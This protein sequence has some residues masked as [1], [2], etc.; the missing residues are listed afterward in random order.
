MVGKHLAPKLGIWKKAIK[1]KI[2]QGDGSSLKGNFIVH[3]LFKAMDSSLVLC[4]FEIDTE[5]WDVGNRNVILGLCWLTETGFAVDIQDRCLRNGNTSK[6][7]CYSVRWIHKVL[8]VEQELV[9]DGKILLKI[10]ASKRY[11]CCGQCFSIEQAARL[12][13]H[14]SW[15]NQIH[16]QDSNTKIPKGQSARPPV[17]KAKASASTYKRIF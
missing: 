12:L 7:I 4:K 16:L 8:I 3:T 1:V 14:K 6:V 13:E 2:R 11:S 9:E 15:N 5:V 17:R 10:D